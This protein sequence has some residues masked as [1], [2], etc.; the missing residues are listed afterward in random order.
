MS[1]SRS[2]ARVL[3][4]GAGGIGAPAALVLARAG[5]GT[6]GVVD[7]DRV[8]RSNLHR[9]VLYREADVGTPKLDALREGLRRFGLA[10]VALEAHAT[11]LLPANAAKLAQ[12]YDVVLEGADNFPTKFLVADA[13]RWV[14]RPVVHA[15]ALGL[16]GTVL[17]VSTSGA[18]CYRCLFEDVPEGDAPNCAT[19]G[20]VGPLVGLVAALAADLALGFV[21]GRAVGGTLVQVNRLDL[22]RR[23]VP[24][25]RGCALCANARA[26]DPQDAAR[27]VAPRCA[28]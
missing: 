11:R 12:A 5:I 15:S 26:F 7:D 13:C 20:V 1:T 28:S 6:L 4:V 24:L 18:P 21:D 9:Q 25:R 8:E 10:G 14:G 2:A 3:L 17:S 27:Y 19:A 23:A 16:V 22:R